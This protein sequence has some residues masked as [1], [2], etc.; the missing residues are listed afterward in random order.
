MRHPAAGERHRNR[1]RRVSVQLAKWMIRVNAVHPTN[2]NT[3]MLHNE[4]L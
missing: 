4:G 2:V 3:D 1:R